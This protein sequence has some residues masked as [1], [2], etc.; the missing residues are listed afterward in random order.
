MSFMQQKIKAIGQVLKNGLLFVDEVLSN[1]TISF[2][3]S[4]CL[5]FESEFTLKENKEEGKEENEDQLSSTPKVKAKAKP[6]TEQETQNI[7][8]ST[9]TDTEPTTG[10]L[11]KPVCSL[12]SSSSSDYG[13]F[14]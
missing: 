4:P 5:T 12:E 13:T 6:T 9:E 2:P 11:L 10:L 7:G 1:L 8:I 14:L 3:M